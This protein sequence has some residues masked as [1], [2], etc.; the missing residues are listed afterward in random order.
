M[1]DPVLLTTRRL[2]VSRGTG[3]EVTRVT[4]LSAA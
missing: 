2:V 3:P 1:K 4:R